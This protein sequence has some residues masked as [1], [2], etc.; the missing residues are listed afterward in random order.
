MLVEGSGKTTLLNT[1]SGQIPADHGTVILNDNIMTKAAR[2]SIGYCIQEDIFLANLT[3]YETLYFTAMLRIPENVPYSEKLAKI[4]E[5]VEAL[6]LADCLKTKIG[7]FLDRGLSGGEKKRANIACE[8]LTDPDILLVD[9]PTTGLDSSTALLMMQQLTSYANVHDK[10][11]IITIHQPSS[12][13][14][15]TLNKLLLLVHGQTAYFG[16]AQDAVR[17][18]QPLNIPQRQMYNPADYLMELLTADDRLIDQIHLLASNKRQEEAFMTKQNHSHHQQTIISKSNEHSDGFSKQ[19]VVFHDNLDNNSHGK[20]WPTTFWTQYY[21][22][23]WRNF[24]Q[25]K[26]RLF[27]VPLTLPVLWTALILGMMYFHISKELD[28]LRDR[29]G[30]LVWVF[31]FSVSEEREVVTKERRVGAYRL[32]AYYLAKISSELPLLIVMPIVFYSI[33]YWMTML[34]GVPEFFIFIGVNIMHCLC[35]Q[36]VGHVFGAL[37]FDASTAVT[38]SQTFNICAFLAAGMFTTHFP[39]WLTWFKYLS[40]MHYPYAAMV[41]SILSDVTPILCNNTAA[42]TFEVCKTSEYLTGKDVLTSYGVELPIYCYLATLTII[43]FL[44]KVFGYL[45]FKLKKA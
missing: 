13:M 28:T 40:F 38:S 22:L 41:T 34:G 21:L 32:S 8:L 14:F 37:I 4:D 27:R 15:R 19:E 16:N 24:K 12:Q 9:E 45:A 20:I 44:L 11:V 18:F 33:S 10:I 36:G 29:M 5:T 17:Y 6:N 30:M 23:T 43:I 35:T 2:R 7:D 1:L 3:L 25:V 42:N 31:F 39:P 26:G